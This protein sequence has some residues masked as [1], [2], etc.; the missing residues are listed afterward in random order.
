LLAS[1]SATILQYSRNQKTYLQA[2][3]TR[4]RSGK[5]RKKKKK[6]IT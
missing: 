6:V 5:K 3:D 2:E 1:L 4:P